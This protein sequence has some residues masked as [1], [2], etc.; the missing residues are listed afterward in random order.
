MVRCSRHRLSP[1][2]DWWPHGLPAPGSGSR[3]LRG[4]EEVGPSLAEPRCTVGGGGR[5]STL[6]YV[7][8]REAANGQASP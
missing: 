6:A 1:S 7:V 4:V 2:T 3:V 5:V 8:D